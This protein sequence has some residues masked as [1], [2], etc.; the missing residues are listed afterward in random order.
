M[1]ATWQLLS[2]PSDKTGL[3]VI[4]QKKGIRGGKTQLS[5]SCRSMEID[6]YCWND[7]SLLVV[8]DDIHT[9]DKNNSHQPRLNI[10]PLK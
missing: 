7:E 1:K 9:L 3:R 10:Q 6:H 8:V 4:R 5:S 2:W